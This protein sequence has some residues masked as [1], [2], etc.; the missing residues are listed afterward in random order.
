MNCAWYSLYGYL[1]IPKFDVYVK[2]QRHMLIAMWKVDTWKL[3]KSATLTGHWVFKRMLYFRQ[4]VTGLIEVATGEVHSSTWMK[5]R[6]HFSCLN[7]FKILH[8]ENVFLGEQTASATIHALNVCWKQNQLSLRD[9]ST[10]RNF[11]YQRIN[12][13]LRK[14]VSKSV[15]TGSR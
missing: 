13:Q 4:L 9:A 12:C 15:E 8:R 14:I 2:V 11:D 7:Q 1:V 6:Q 5:W 10:I 3:V